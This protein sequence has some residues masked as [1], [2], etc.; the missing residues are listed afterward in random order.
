MP[1]FYNISFCFGE[2]FHLPRRGASVT[3]LVNINK[4]YFHLA[5]F[6]TVTQTVLILKIFYLEINNI[7]KS[8]LISMYK[9]RV[10]CITC[11]ISAQNA[12]SKFVFRF[13]VKS[14]N[15]QHCASNT[16]PCCIHCNATT[17]SHFQNASIC[18]V[19]A[20]LVR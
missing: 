18:L 8:E 11:M 5:P 19:T 20:L 3:A 10:D 14:K 6:P 12:I 13:I 16:A 17:Y 15:I 9:I 4:N 7:S 2:F 1:F